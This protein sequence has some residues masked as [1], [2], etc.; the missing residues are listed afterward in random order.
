MSRALRGVGSAVAV[1][2]LVLA[3]WGLVRWGAAVHGAR[4]DRTV[5]QGGPAR[6]AAWLV[7]RPPTRRMETQRREVGDVKPLEFIGPF[8][9]AQR[10]AQLVDG[11]RRQRGIS[12]AVVC[13]LDWQATESVCEESPQDALADALTVKLCRLGAAGGDLPRCGGIKGPQLVLLLSREAR[14]VVRQ[15]R[16]DCAL[17][18]CQIAGW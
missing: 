17:R 14:V 13:S 4:Q 3:C 8:A 9:D 5:G 15:R 12:Q 7:R 11:M 2:L 18:A 6:L 16:T 10:T 1:A